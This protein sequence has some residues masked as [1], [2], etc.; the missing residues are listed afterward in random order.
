MTQSSEDPHPLGAHLERVTSPRIEVLPGSTGLAASYSRQGIFGVLHLV[1]LSKALPQSCIAKPHFSGWYWV[2][3]WPALLPK[4][5]RWVSVVPAQRA[6]GTK[7]SDP[8]PAPLCRG[9]RG[10]EAWDHRSPSSCGR[11]ETRAER[12][13]ARSRSSALRFLPLL[14]PAPAAGFKA[15]GLPGRSGAELA[16]ADRAGELHEK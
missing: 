3:L 14:A 5:P 8:A 16:P 9:C 7:G 15:L 10:A 6:V 13:T 2:S 12:G 11:W 1:E 4:P